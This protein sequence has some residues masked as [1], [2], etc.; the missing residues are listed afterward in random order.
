MD[1]P[2][3]LNGAA[4]PL[5]INGKKEETV[6]FPVAASA[7]Q[8]RVLNAFGSSSSRQSDFEEE[9]RDDSPFQADDDDSTS[10]ST[11]HRRTARSRSP[12]QDFIEKAAGGGVDGASGGTEA[13]AS[14]ASSSGSSLSPTAVYATMLHANNIVSNSVSL[15][16]TRLPNPPTLIEHE[17]LR[18]LIMDAP[19]QS[20]LKLYLREMERHG[21][22]DVVRVCDPTY[23]REMVEG[24]GISVHDWVFPDGDAPPDAVIRRWLLLVNDRFGL[25]QRDAALVV[26]T[27]AAV[28]VHCVAGLG[29]APVLVAIALIE[30]GMPALDAVKFIR[31]RRRG[32]INNRQLKFL[33][34]YRP[35]LAS[36]VSG[37]A[38]GGRCMLM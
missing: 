22:T 19:S 6:A 1:S 38:A 33:E 17:R 12:G 4:E 13:N 11:M 27:G 36:L 26:P 32:A 8:P 23:A 5:A 28:A 25:V 30:S 31:Q 29:R 16:A 7:P 10:V 9:E 20:N 18:F 15:Q 14:S 21:V 34:G 2:E 24:Q 37:D 35:K 3:F